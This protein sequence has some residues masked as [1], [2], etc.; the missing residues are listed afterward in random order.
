MALTLTAAKPGVRCLLVK[1]RVASGE[2]EQRRAQISH[3]DW[4]NL[5]HLQEQ[6][7]HVFLLL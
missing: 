5:P 1:T 6:P 2:V 4:L 7:C 3:Q